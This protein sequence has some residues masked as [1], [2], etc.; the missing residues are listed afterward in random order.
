MGRST[1]GGAGFAPSAAPVDLDAV[2]KRGRSASEDKVARA[3]RRMRQLG[4]S[5]GAARRY[6][7]AGVFEGVLLDLF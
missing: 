4:V 7:A 1:R 6:I 5:A 2:E 3:A